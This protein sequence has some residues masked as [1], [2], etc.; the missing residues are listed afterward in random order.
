MKISANKLPFWLQALRERLRLEAEMVATQRC[1]HGPIKNNRWTMGYADRFGHGSFQA[2]Y[3]C[4]PDGSGFYR[5]AHP[6]GL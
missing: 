1:F 6:V 5:Y 3:R 2:S 4:G